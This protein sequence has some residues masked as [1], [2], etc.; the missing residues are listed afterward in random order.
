MAVNVRNVDVFYLDEW[1]YTRRLALHLGPPAG[2][3]PGRDPGAGTAGRSACTRMLLAPVNGL[4]G[5]RDAFVIGHLVNVALLASTVVPLALMARRVIASP[6]LRVL[7]VALGT[8][9]PWLM[10]ASHLLTENLAFPLFAWASYAIV[11]T[12]ERPTWRNELAALVAIGAL[13]LCR[14]N[15]AAVFAVLVFAVLDRRALPLPGARRRLARCRSCARGRPPA[16]CSSASATDRRRARRRVG[17]SRAARSRSAR[18]GGFTASTFTDGLLGAGRSETL[19][20]V[21]TYARGLVGGMFVLPFALGLAVGLAGLFGRLGRALAVPSAVVLERAARR[22]SS[23]SRC[24]RRARRWRSATSSHPVGLI[25]ILAVAG[26]ERAGRLRALDRRPAPRSPFWPFVAGLPWPGQLAEHFFAAP[27]KAFWSRVLDARLRQWE[28]RLL[29]LDPDPADRLAAAR[30][31][32]DRARAAG[33]PARPPRAARARG[34]DR[35]P[36][37]VPGRAGAVAQLRLPPGALRHDGQP[38]RDRRPTRPR[39]ERAARVRGRPHRRRARRG[40]AH[41]RPGRPARRRGGGDDVLELGRSPPPSTC[42]GR[43][44]RC[45]CRPAAP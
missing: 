44:P 25:A 32:A 42:A 2:R 14:L 34:A 1:F 24:G 16:P 35:R 38:G 10:I 5:A 43:A 29:G 7:A 17:C 22:C 3:L 6:W 40:A 26:V 28:G 27:G 45:P 37:A 33:A 36:R 39:P 20:T 19:R 21:L 41:A 12:A 4:F 8:V 30:R 23:S 15:L 9:V 13:A 18:Y 11:V 31:R